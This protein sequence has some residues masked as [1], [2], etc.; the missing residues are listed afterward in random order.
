M[1][2]SLDISFSILNP[3]NKRLIYRRRVSQSVFD[4][5]KKQAVY[6]IG[7]QETKQGV[8]NQMICFLFEDGHVEVVDGFREDHPWFYSINFIK[9]ERI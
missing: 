7:W 8:N 4:N 6:L 5:S 2:N 1:N 9:E 3:K